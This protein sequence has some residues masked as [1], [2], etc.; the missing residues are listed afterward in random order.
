MSQ[1]LIP[2]K[3]T[4]ERG[5][6]RI[7]GDESMQD[8]ARRLV[9]TNKYDQALRIYHDIYVQNGNTIAGYNNAV[10]LAA[11]KKFSQSLELLEDLSRKLLTS[12]RKTPR[13]IRKEIQKMSGIVNGYKILEEYR[14]SRDTAAGAHTGA[15]P[16]AALRP[17]ADKGEQANIRELRGTINL[18]FATVYVLRESITSAADTTVW[19]KIVASAEVSSDDPNAL[20]AVWSVRIPAAAPVLLRFTVM[21]GSSGLYITQ[22]A[23]NSSGIVVLDTAQMIKLE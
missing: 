19:S 15:L 7:T 2:W 4:E 13:L 20:G 17:A 18:N 14:I 9:R 10:L 3:T 11:Q 5:I 8:E 1:E 21:D 22:T 23:L 6:R 12:G 16:E